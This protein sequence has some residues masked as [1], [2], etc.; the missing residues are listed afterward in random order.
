MT[1]QRHPAPFPQPESGHTQK[2]NRM[3]SLI[4]GRVSG[5]PPRQRGARSRLARTGAA[6]AALSVGFSTFG[7]AAANAA[8]PVF[9]GPASNGN[10]YIKNY[11]HPTYG[12]DYG[13][14]LYYDSDQTRN[15]AT[16]LGAIGTAGV[17]DGPAICLDPGLD[18]PSAV[19]PGVATN[20]PFAAYLFGTYI[21]PGGTGVP[22]TSAAAT[23]NT[24]AAAYLLKD[25]YGTNASMNLLDDVIDVS[26][27]QDSAEYS[28][29]K[30]RV[31]ALRSAAT[32]NANLELSPEIEVTPGSFPST[33][34]IEDVGVEDGAG[35]RAGL[36]ITVTLSGPAKFENG[37]NTWTG[38][39]GTDPVDLPWTATGNGTISFDATVDG[40]WSTVTIHRAVNRDEQRALTGAQSQLK[41]SDPTGAKVINSF[42]PK[43][44]TKTSNVIAEP[45]QPLHDIVSVSDG[46]EGQEFS[47]TS[48]LYG[49][50]A[51]EPAQESAAAP[52][53]TPVV[54]TAT[55]SGTFGP[56]GKAEVNT[57][58]LVVPEA[59]YYVWQETLAET[60]NSPPYTGPFGQKPETTLVYNPKL[61]TAINLQKATVGQTISDSVIVDGIRTSVGGK[62]ITNTVSGVLAGPVA[63]VD[64]ECEA[65]DWEGATTRDIEPFVVTKSGRI[66]G[67]DEHVI[68]V[69]GCYT[70]GETLTVTLEGQDKPVLVVDHP[71]GK[72]EQTVLVDLYRPTG[73]TKVTTTTPAAGEEVSDVWYGQGGKPGTTQ[74]GVWARYDITGL[75]GDAIKCTDGNLVEEGEFEITYGED[76]TVTSDK[77]GTYTAAA[78]GKVYTF[79]DALLED[80]FNAAATHDC[81][82][83]EETVTHPQVPAPPADS[84]GGAIASGVAGSTGWNGGLLGLAS[85]LIL[86]AGMGVLVART[87]KT[88]DQA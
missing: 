54:G 21:R 84:S 28:A 34:T 17:Y 50:L 15:D 22:G 68:D 23:R 44:T 55:F 78:D 4:T 25:K 74:K 26:L 41:Y 60:P 64:G 42:S 88:V 12:Q 11:D 56:D 65:V 31:S 49:P 14:R 27:A 80:D 77:F 10:T 69:A 24:A 20:D 61:S 3:L 5:P 71:I 75:T 2:G 33:G 51:E 82:L 79:V 63:P 36:P 57:T 19:T 85:G 46:I 8:L 70:Y 73:N 9:V 7:A 40:I 1:S 81:G 59:G 16:T 29:F 67:V 39:T 62:A 43:A 83:P 47:G 32:R 66:D 38:T 48:T 52:A 86:L 58:E 35:W 53:G 30:G 18:R 76:G 45:G 87:R 13:Y 6:V 72:V 37:T